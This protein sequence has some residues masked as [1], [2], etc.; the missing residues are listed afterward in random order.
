MNTTNVNSGE[1]GGL[2]RCLKHEVP[3]L[4]CVGYNSLKL[5]LYFKHSIPQAT[6]QQTIATILML[7]EVFNCINVMLLTFQKSHGSI[8]LNDM[9][10]Y[11]EITV[12]NLWQCHNNVHTT[13][14][15]T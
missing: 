10:T 2:K 12:H 15:K 3:L 11:T 7:L 5:A 14:I 13:I 1:K 6:T 4:L 9:E 8:S